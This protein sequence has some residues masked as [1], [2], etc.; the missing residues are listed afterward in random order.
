MDDRHPKRRK[1]KYN[2]YTL[3]IQNGKY[4]LAFKDGQGVHHQMEISETLYAL[5]NSFELDDLSHL[6]EWDRHIEQSELS[7][8]TLENRMAELPESVEE[9]VC[10]QFLYEQLHRA[11]DTLPMMQRR[12]VILYFFYDLT[13]EEIAKVEGCTVMPIK[14]SI[15]RALKKIKKNFQNRG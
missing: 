11:I 6:N 14:R 3:T 1:D 2:P 7:D 8:A 10:K 13:Y 9:T 15:D 4:Y 5:M 12:R